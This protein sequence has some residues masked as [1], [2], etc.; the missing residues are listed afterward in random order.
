MKKAEY[1]ITA[2]LLVACLTPIKA[3]FFGSSPAVGFSAGIKAEANWSNFILVGIP[4][5]ESKMNAGFSLGAFVKTEMSA[6]FAEQEELLVHYKTS[7]FEQGDIKGGYRYWGVEIPMYNVVHWKTKHGIKFYV[8]IGPYAELGLSAEYI[9]RG[10]VTDLYAENNGKVNLTHLSLGAASVI[11]IQF[12]S[13]VQVNA[14]YNVGLTNALAS[15]SD[16]S[17]A[18]ASTFHFGL[19]YLFN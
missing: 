11:G 16:E 13:N 7:S 10:H 6:H 3:Q 2:L 5:V 17:T 14:G 15:K 4:D 12:A 1:W 18:Y 8:G 9:E 19:A